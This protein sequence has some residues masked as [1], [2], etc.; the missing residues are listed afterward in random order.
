MTT[1]AT[2]TGLIVEFH[3]IPGA[4]MRVLN[5]FTRRGLVIQ[6]VWCAP[7]GDRHRATVLV[8]AKPVTIE[9]TVREL[10]STVGVDHVE[11]LEQPAAEQ[12]SH[13]QSPEVA[14]ENGHTVI[15]VSGPPEENRF[16]LE[17]LGWSHAK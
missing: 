9:Q 5:C 1:T 7:V 6:A 13:W 16:L 11:V 17:W 10:I 15:R 8:E 14:S 12:L 4:L 2:T 3:N